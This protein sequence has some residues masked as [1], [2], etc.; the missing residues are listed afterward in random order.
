MI[1]KIFESLFIDIS[2]NNDK[3]TNGI[4]CLQ[5]TKSGINSQQ[6]VYWSSNTNIKSNF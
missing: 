1:E 3:L 2:L 4:Y 5:I 6:A